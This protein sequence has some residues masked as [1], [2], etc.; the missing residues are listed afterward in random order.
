MG[1]QSKHS[2]GRE[3]W[4]VILVGLSLLLLISLILLVNL[5]PSYWVALTVGA[6]RVA[7]QRL[8]GKPKPDVR[9]EW[10]EKERDL[11]IKEFEVERE[12]ARKEREARKLEKETPA[13]PKIVDR[14]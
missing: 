3:I 9:G 5:R 6:V 4:A 13:D 7:W 1:R 14:T 11:R 2:H 8:R 10:R 12:V